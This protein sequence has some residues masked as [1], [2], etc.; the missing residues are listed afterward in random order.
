L[1]LAA[2][3]LI[4]VMVVAI[5]TVHLKNGFFNTGGGYEFNLLLIAVAVALL[6][7][8]SG[9]YGIDAALGILWS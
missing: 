6:L 5:V 7:A 4:A 8:G 2:L 1:P 3:A 9:A